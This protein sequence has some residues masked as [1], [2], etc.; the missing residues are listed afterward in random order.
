MM[1]YASLSVLLLAPRAASAHDG[2][3][4][5][6]LRGAAPLRRQPLVRHRLAGAQGALHRGGLRL[7]LRAAQHARVGRQ[8]RGS[9]VVQLATIDEASH[10]LETMGGT[11]LGGR[12]I[13]VRAE[14][15]SRPGRA[16]GRVRG[17][18]GARRRLAARRAARRRVR[19]G[20]G[21]GDDRRARR[22]SGGG[23]RTTRPTRCATT[24]ARRTACS[25]TTASASGGSR[26]TIAAAAAAAAPVTPAA[27]SAIAA[28][29]SPKTEA[30]K[31][32]PWRRTEGSGDE[33]SS[34]AMR[35]DEEEVADIL[36]RRDALRDARRFDEADRLL[37][38]LAAMHVYVDD[39]RRQ[40]V[41]WVGSRADGRGRRPRRSRR[42][43]PRRRGVAST[44]TRAGA[45]RGGANNLSGSS[46]ETFGQPAEYSPGKRMRCRCFRRRP[47]PL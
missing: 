28:A 36:A 5:V 8:P 24:C 25:P 40:R 21:G 43:A 15:L 1:F 22:A 11:T 10:A 32:K 12:Q 39:G 33:D 4:P 27:A 16:A 44:G 23:R 26:N 34:A 45:G 47:P 29:A 17:V 20:G 3:R 38:Q 41:W 7:R 46:T 19:R 9:G 6:L 18:G 30:W 35:L 14:R 37:S 2:P 42:A 31:N 13:R